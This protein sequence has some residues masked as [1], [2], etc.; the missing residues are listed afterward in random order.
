MSPTALT[1]PRDGRDVAEAR[2]RVRRASAPEATTRT[3][4]TRICEGLGSASENHSNERDWLL[5]GG[6]D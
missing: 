4:T 2:L 5:G 1:A 6:G 3:R